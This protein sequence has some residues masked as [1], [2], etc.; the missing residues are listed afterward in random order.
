MLEEQ[1]KQQDQQK[2]DK[3]DKQD[4]QEQEEQ[5]Q[6][7]KDQQGDENKQDEQQKKE[8]EQKDQQKQNQDSKNEQSDQEKDKQEQNKN[9][10][11]PKEVKGTELTEQLNYFGYRQNIEKAIKDKSA[12]LA[13][14]DS[15]IQTKAEKISSEYGISKEEAVIRLANIQSREYIINNLSS[16]IKDERAVKAIQAIFDI[17]KPAVSD[18]IVTFIKSCAQTPSC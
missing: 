8:Q 16:V 11:E 4:K 18:N 15:E 7:N 1:K 17:T 2:Q 5:N 9:K 13:L 3:Q 14:N 12:E 6:D 10:S